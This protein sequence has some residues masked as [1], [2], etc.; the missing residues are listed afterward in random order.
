MSKKTP[1]Q[2]GKH[3]QMPAIAETLNLKPSP[4]LSMNKLSSFKQYNKAKS[5]FFGLLL[6]LST[7]GAI[8]IFQIL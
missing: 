6:V 5:R 8:L 4:N 2:R 7:L 1:L 3:S